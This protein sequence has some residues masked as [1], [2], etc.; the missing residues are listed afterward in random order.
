MADLRK[1]LQIPAS[2]LEEINALLLDPNSATVSDLLDV[3]E[4]YGGPEEINRQAEGPASSKPHD[5]PPGRPSTPYLK[6][7]HWLIEQRDGG[8]HLH[9]DYRQRVPRKPDAAATAGTPSRWR[10]APCNTSPG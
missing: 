7:L 10:S 1:L 9:A 6:D 4:R 5:A 2:R 8:L 3:V